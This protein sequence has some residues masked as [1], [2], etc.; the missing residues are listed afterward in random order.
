M[1]QSKRQRI[2]FTIIY[3]LFAV[4]LAFSVRFGFVSVQSKLMEKQAVRV[5]DEWSYQAVRSDKFIPVAEFIRRYPMESGRPYTMV[6]ILPETLIGGEALY[7]HS[8][9]L[10][11]NI[12]IGGERVYSLE[13]KG[14]KGYTGDVENIVPLPNGSEGQPIRIEYYSKGTYRY[15]PIDAVYI[16][17]ES[18]FVK[19]VFLKDL[20]LLLIAFL[21]VVFA[22]VQLISAIIMHGKNGTQ[23]Y[24]LSWVSCLYG[25]WM[26]GTSGVLDFFTNYRLSSHGL[27]CLAL[28]M[29]SY[30]LLVYF[31]MQH[32]IKGATADCVL[33]V[34]SGLNF[35]LVLILKFVFHVPLEYSVLFSYGLICIC[36]ARVLFELFRQLRVSINN[37]QGKGKGNLK[38]I[39]FGVCILA[40]GTVIDMARIIFSADNGWF[41]FSPVGFFC[42]MFL[43]SGRSLANA[44]DMIQLGKKSETVQQLAYFDILTQVYNRTALNEDMEKL[45]KVKKEKKN[46]GIVVFDVNNL[47]WVNDNL[48]HL[49]GDKLLQDA[50]RVIRDGFEGYGKAYRFGGDEFVVV[51]EERAKEKYAFGIQQMEE[52]LIKQNAACKRDERVSIAYGVSYYDASDDKTLWQVHE[53]ADEQMY[54]RKRRMKARM[55]DGKDVRKSV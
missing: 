28:S 23:L 15:K 40:I 4:G 55:N 19:S 2:L 38:G 35:P 39:T 41:Y 36:F 48:G 8:Q 27:S 18:Q 45:E 49:A 54:E 16:G 33:K 26:F 6:G 17:R 51:I 37:Y 11:L 9:N 52:L 20:I 47:K 46:L 34:V 1:Q 32:N 13:S 53:A 24:Y 29:I 31:C 7:F 21:C 10:N 42:M 25:I 43:L 14:G 3:L 50:A 12:F 5:S 22:I 30:P 44:L